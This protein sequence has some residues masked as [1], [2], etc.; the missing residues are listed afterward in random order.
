MRTFEYDTPSTTPTVEQPCPCCGQRRPL[1]GNACPHCRIR[2]SDW[3]A[4]LPAQVARLS[5]CLVPGSAPAGDRV[6]TSRTGSP[7]PARLDILSLVGPGTGHVRIDERHLIPHVRRWSTTETVKSS[8]DGSEIEVTVWHRAVDRGP[9]GRPLLH[10]ADDQIGMI[11]PVEWVRI[12]VEAWRQAL[13]YSR[14]RRGGRDAVAA[15]VR[16]LEA[17]LDDVCDRE[18]ADIPRFYAELR[19]MRAELERALGETPDRV[20]LGRC[21]T[22]LTARDTGVE[23][24]CGMSLWHDPH[25]SVISCARCRSTWATQGRGW[26]DLAMAIRRIWPIDRRRRYTLTEAEEAAAS[27]WAPACRADGCRTLLPLDWR[28]ATEP[29][30]KARMWRPEIGSCP[31][32]HDEIEAAA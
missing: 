17:W 31:T 20:Y 3:L 28:D 15:G 14:P 5:A 29:R 12:Q 13:G 32:V 24:P 1:V 11:P 10:L 21:P 27:A 19:T 26:L 30:D 8:T 6:S 4:D 9:D 7:T 23:T 2:M 25:A 18:L 16:H 22:L